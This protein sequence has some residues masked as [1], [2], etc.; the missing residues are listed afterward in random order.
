MCFHPAKNILPAPRAQINRA[1]K[2]NKIPCLHPK[3]TWTI[4]TLKKVMDIVKKG[5]FQ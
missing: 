3:G 2:L 1:K 4:E 5:H